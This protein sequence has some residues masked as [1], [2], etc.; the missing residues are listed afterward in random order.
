MERYHYSDQEQ[1]FLENLKA[2]VA[3]FQLVDKRIIP[4]ALSDGFCTLLGTET[5]DQAYHDMEHNTLQH[6]H[7]DDAARVGNAVLKFMREDDTFD[8]IYRLV[9]METNGY[10]VIHAVGK[11]VFMDT[12][13]RVAQIWYTDEGAYSEG[14]DRQGSELNQTLTNALHEES[15]LKANYYDDLTGLP[16]LTYF[17]DLAEAGKEAMCKRGE[18]SALLYIDLDGMKYYNHKFSFVEGDK[19]LKSFAGLLVSVFSADNCGHIGADRF[20]VFTREDLLED[21]LARLFREARE[22]N[23][24]NSLPVRVG[25]YSSRIELVPVSVAYDRAKIACDA[26]KKTENSSYNY[27]SEELRDYVKKSQYIQ[28]NIDRAISEK[29]IKVYYQPIIRAVNERVCDVEALARWIDPVE[30]FLSPADFIPF[31]EDA[32][33]IY[34]LDLY[35]LEQVLEKMTQQ[36]ATG[37]HIVPHSINLSRSDFDACD[38]VEEIRKRVDNA[39]ISRSKITIEITESIIGSDFYFMKEQVERFQR[40]GFP[41]WMDDFGSGYSSLDVLQSIRFNLLKFDMSFMEKLNE[42][43]SGKIILTELMK[44]ATSLGVDTVCEGVETKEQVRFLQEIGCSKFQG[45]YYSKPIPF[46]VIQQSHQSG[47]QI[48]YEN[49]EESLYYDA[50]GRLNLF[51]LAVVANMSE[52]VFQN[53]FNT[54]PMGILEV[55]GDKARFVR[56]NQSY[57]GFISRFFHLDLS[58][59]GGEFVKFNDAFMHNIVKTCC[60]NVVR[61]FYDE[62]MPDGSIVHSFARRIG[63]NPVN[64]NIAIA[65]AVLTISDPVEGESYADIARALAADYYNIYVVDLDTE[66]YIEYSSQAGQEELAMERH[67]EKFFEACKQAAYRIYAEDR[68]PFFSAFSKEKIIQALDE[69]GVFTATY[70]LMDTGTPVYVSMKVTRMRQTENRIIMGISIIDTQMKQKAHE[71]ELKKERDALVRIIA[72]SDGYLSLFT[73]DPATEQYIE[74]SSSDDEDCLSL[75]KKGDHFFHQALADAEKAIAPEDRTFFMERFT[76]EN[77]LQAIRETGVFKLQYHLMMNG[78]PRHVALKIAPF[79]E[80]EHEEKLLIGVRVWRERQG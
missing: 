62:R 35:V 68:E 40:L 56:S 22:I 67:G 30:G 69:R 52:N 32:G 47:A 21:A 49:P 4:L 74:Y 37:L 25:I 33:L 55:N 53:T 16:N 8:C 6:V 31:L 71:E 57:R 11:H 20:S 73:V 12:G 44:M 61:S 78:E 76:K 72:L 42:G 5:R 9:D 64:G 14:I 77:I 51:D 1:S 80:S 43:E 46:E 13:V 36:A 17:F 24:G 58:T 50:I 54:L 19:L 34:K 39:G 66:R 28:K 79:K 38:I 75:V 15:I 23:G 63:E 26:L 59:Q 10:R 70:R 27:Y 18:N 41:V 3:V 45:Y 48:A 65:V 2:P 60:N 29:W 7:Q